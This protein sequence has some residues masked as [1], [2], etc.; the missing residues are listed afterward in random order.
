VYAAGKSRDS[1][2]KVF[3]SFL[4]KRGLCFCTAH[5]QKKTSD[6]SVLH[7]L[8][9]TISHLQPF[10][11]CVA[12]GFWVLAAMSMLRAM[13][14]KAPRWHA[15]RGFVIGFIG[16]GSIIASEFV[17][18]DVINVAAQREI[19]AIIGARLLSVTVNGVSA[20]R[21]YDVLEA[22]KTMRFPLAHH[23]HPTTRF[24]V[25]IDTSAGSAVLVFRRDSSDPHEYWV[26]YPKFHSTN[27]NAVGHAFTDS[28]DS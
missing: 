25:R 27:V 22:V 2:I 26:F 7:W 8:D 17:C 9:N 23:S 12:I 14:A 3:T 5:C 6:I 13:R 16:F 1:D 24:E 4:V 28:L 11:L 10:I 21:K 20:N 19:A 15:P 18:A